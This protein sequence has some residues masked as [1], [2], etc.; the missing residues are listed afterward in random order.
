MLSICSFE[1]CNRPHESRGYCHSHGRQLR[2][3]KPLTPL[4]L[5]AHLLTG[6]EHPVWRGNQVKYIA[7]HQRVHRLKGRAANHTCHCG[8]Q[9]QEWAYD[10]GC[11]DELIDDRGRKY[12]PNPDYYNPMCRS[13]H[14]AFDRG[15][16]LIA[17]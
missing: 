12:S 13:C 1:G 5:P 7:A 10:G 8:S 9:A 3:G 11:P 4:G 17:A 15:W 16:R 14:R 2:A 6:M